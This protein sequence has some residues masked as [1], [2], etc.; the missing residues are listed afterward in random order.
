MRRWLVATVIYLI[1]A[2]SLQAKTLGLGFWINDRLAQTAAQKQNIE[3]RLADQVIEL[4]AFFRNSHVQLQADIAVIRYVRISQSD[5]IAI[6]DDMISE[7]NEFANLFAVAGEYGADY[8]IAIVDKL[9]LR[10]NPNCGRAYAVNK[11][12]NEIASLQRAIVA[13]NSAC[14][15]QTLAHEL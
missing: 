8:N 15:A 11:T 9:Q 1:S 10:G 14:S 13:V 3:K 6:L 5:A 7:R 12:Q 2:A 4:N